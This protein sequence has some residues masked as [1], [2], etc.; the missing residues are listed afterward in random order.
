MLTFLRAGTFHQGHGGHAL[1]YFRK[2]AIELVFPVVAIRHAMDRGD[3]RA[4]WRVVRIDL[5][6]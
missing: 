6:G 1:E 3:A 5:C 4:A 2:R